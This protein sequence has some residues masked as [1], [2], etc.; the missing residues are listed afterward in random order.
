MKYSSLFFVTV[1]YPPEKS[2]IPLDNSATAVCV[3]LHRLHPIGQSVAF[4]NYN[5]V[6]VAR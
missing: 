3:F 5:D 6:E 2:S 4:G 1:M